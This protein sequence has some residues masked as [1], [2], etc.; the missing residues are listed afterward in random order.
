MHDLTNGLPATTAGFFTAP[1][2]LVDY[3]AAHGFVVIQ[4]TYLDSRTVG[5]ALDD[6]R[7]PRVWRFRVED[8]KCILDQVDVLEAAVPGLS[9]RLDRG[10]I[11]AAGHSFGSQTTGNLLG[12]R[13]RDPQTGIEDDLS[14]PRIKAGVLLAT[15]GEGGPT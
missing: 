8:V 1:C 11:A 7:A 13:V 15:V 3:W 5:M 12:L 14:D 9:G 4:P 10:R 6:P 2:P